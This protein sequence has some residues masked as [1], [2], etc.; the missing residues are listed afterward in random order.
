[1]IEKY[2]FGAM[3]VDGQNYA[4]DLIIF[5][6]RINPAWWRKEGHKLTREDLEDVFKEDVE[7]LVVGTGFF[8]LMKVHEDVIE[9]AQASGL[10]LHVEKTKKAVEI[11][12][13]L[14][15]QKKT[16]GAFHLTC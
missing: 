6:S 1:M 4:A 15:S 10:S 13:Q 5:P 14:Y 3:V 7:A 9:A 11:F 16:A 12:N 8:G 2:D